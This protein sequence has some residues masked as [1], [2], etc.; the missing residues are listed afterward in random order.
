MSET[1]IKFGILGC[2]D[3]ARKVGRAISLAPNATIV[4]VGSCSAQ[5]AAKFAADHGFP[6]GT[7][8]T[9][10][11]TPSSTTRSLHAKWAV[12]AAQKKKH[13]IL[14]KPVAVDVAEFDKIVEAC[15][16][17]CVQFM[18]GTMT[19]R[20]KEFISDG[21]AFGKLRAMHTCFTFAADPV[22]LEN[23]IR[24]KPDLDALGALGDADWYCIW[25]IL[26]GND[27]ELPRTMTT[28]RGPLF[29]KAGVILSCGASL[30]WEDGRVATFHCSFLSHLTM[31]ITAVGM[32]GTLH[33]HD[34]IIPFQESEASFSVASESGFD[35]KPAEHLVST[36]LPQ[37]AMMVKEFSSLVG[38]IKAKGSHPEMRWPII[39]RKTQLVIDAVKLS[40]ERRF[41]PVEILG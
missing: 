2:A 3:I 41:E 28:S 12:L 35:G 15:V 21:R 19:A 4:A 13:L 14:Q 11:R 25:A 5:K 26:W 37:E 23:D 6:P 31:D 10:L 38:A 27:Y 32:K 33:V 39:S 1:V 29:N 40:I 8:S 9:A 30:D 16:A 24:V 22:F 7:Q 20:M 36:S 34:F 18:D 17:S